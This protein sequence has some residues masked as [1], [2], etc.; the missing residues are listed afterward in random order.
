MT[1]IENP[2][3]FN[4]RMP[5]FGHFLSF[6]VVTANFGNNFVLTFLNSF[7]FLCNYNLMNFPLSFLYG[8]ANIFSNIRCKDFLNG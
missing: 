7:F 2:I 5:H 3:S 1:T 6:L 4:C 8:Y